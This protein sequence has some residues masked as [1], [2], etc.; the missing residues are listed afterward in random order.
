VLAFLNNQYANAKVLCAST[1]VWQ[2]YANIKSIKQKI[3][4]TT[5]NINVDVRKVYLE[6][7]DTNHKERMQSLFLPE[8]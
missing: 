4:G 2:N 6:L 1:L 7:D 3:T 8:F 5:N